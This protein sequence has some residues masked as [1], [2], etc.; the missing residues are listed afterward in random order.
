MIQTK[1]EPRFQRGDRVKVKDDT[2]AYVVAQ[3]NERD[4]VAILIEKLTGFPKRVPIEDLRA[5]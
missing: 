1:R 3:L 4:G 5:A 2:Q